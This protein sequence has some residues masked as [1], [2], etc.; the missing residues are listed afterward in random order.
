MP[1]SV[2][3]MIWPSGK[4]IMDAINVAGRSHANNA[5]YE[6]TAPCEKS[7]TLIQSRCIKRTEGGGLSIQTQP[8]VLIIED[9]KW[10]PRALC[11]GQREKA[12]RQ[13]RD[14]SR[15]APKSSR[16][17]TRAG[18]ASEFHPPRFA[19]RAPSKTA[20][21]RTIKASSKTAAAPPETKSR[22]KCTP[23]IPSRFEIVESAD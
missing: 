12:A 5:R 6:S 23:D 19:A 16:H 9:L 15:R 10:H 13:C 14:K 1:S 8:S 17:R 21:E 18:R 2:K 22:T 20:R 7:C 4:K 3:N 11:E